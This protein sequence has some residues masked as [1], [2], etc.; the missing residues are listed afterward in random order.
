M[1]T[2]APYDVD[3]LVGESITAG[4][5][6][7]FGK[8]EGTV[9]ESP[10]ARADDGEL[11]VVAIA[12]QPRETAVGEL[13]SA[14]LAPP[15]R[16]SGMRRVCRVLTARQPAL[17]TRTL[18]QRLCDGAGRCWNE[19][20]SPRSLPLAWWV[21]RVRSSLRCCRPGRSPA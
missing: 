3:I 14:R 21:K 18:S 20:R 11:L 2:R 5:D 13:I 7:P 15:I 10:T 9:V 1:L 6:I 17:P 8:V 19:P 16:A 4:L 12:A